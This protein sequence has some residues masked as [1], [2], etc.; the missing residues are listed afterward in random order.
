MSIS[1]LMFLLQNGVLGR[2][3]LLFFWLLHTLKHYWPMDDKSAYGVIKLE[4]FIFRFD[5]KFFLQKNLKLACMAVFRVPVSIKY[6]SL[7]SFSVSQ[8]ILFDIL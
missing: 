3:K 8:S 4:T 6:T 2:G 7:K 1:F 5:F